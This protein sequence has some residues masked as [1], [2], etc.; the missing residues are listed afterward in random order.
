MSPMKPLP[1]RIS[2]RGRALGQPV[3]SSEA[4]MAIERTV[5]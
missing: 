2:W 1:G 5:R 4:V 3:R